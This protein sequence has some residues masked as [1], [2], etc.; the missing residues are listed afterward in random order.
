M[1]AAEGVCIKRK[2]KKEGWRGRADGDE[3]ETEKQND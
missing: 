3:K 2:D 1:T